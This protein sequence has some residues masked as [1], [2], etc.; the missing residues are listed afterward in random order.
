[1]QG[2]KKK[3]YRS[4]AKNLFETTIIFL[5]SFVEKISQ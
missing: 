5:S 4:Y 1:M 3:N 2:A